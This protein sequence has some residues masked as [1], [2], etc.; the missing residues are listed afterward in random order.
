MQWTEPMVVTKL[1]IYIYILYQLISHQ[2]LDLIVY[3]NSL[4]LIHIVSG[5]VEPYSHLKSIPFS[6]PVEYILHFYQ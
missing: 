4:P 1:Y 5:V 3:S 2:V 6:T